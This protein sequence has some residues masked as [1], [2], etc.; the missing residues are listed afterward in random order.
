MV[1]SGAIGMGAGKL[2]IPRPQDMP[3]KQ[4]AASVGQCELMYTYDRL[5]SAY[6]HTVAQ[7]LV[8][9]EDFDSPSRLENLQN[10]VYRL[11]QLNAIPII[12]ENDSV[13]T[14]EIAVGDNDTMGALVAKYTRAD[15]LVVLS[16]I[17]GL[18]TADPHTHPEATRIEVVREITPDIAALAGGVHSGPGHRRHGHQDPGRA[19]RHRRRGGYGDR[20]RQHPCPALRH[21]GGQ[22]GGHPIYRPETR[23]YCLK[24]PA[25]A[26]AVPPGLFAGPCGAGPGPHPLPLCF[27]KEAFCIDHA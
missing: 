13:A 6:S 18:Y 3:T 4:A 12:N 15:L 8:T 26:R 10:T 16:D 25:A 2:Q 1:S 20:Q 9:R 7:I 23:P 11:L 21:C 27:L 19:H 14:E 5:F 22:S 17:D 24:R